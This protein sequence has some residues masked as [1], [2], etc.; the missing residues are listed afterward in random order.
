MMNEIVELKIGRAPYF[1]FGICHAAFVAAAT[2]EWLEGHMANG[3]IDYIKIM[4][5]INFFMILSYLPLAWA[6]V[7]ID[8]RFLTL[9]RFPTY[10]RVPLESI[11]RLKRGVG[12]RGRPFAAMFVMYRKRNGT[13]GELVIPLDSYPRPTVQRFFASLQAARPDLKVPVIGKVETPRSWIL[14]GN[15]TPPE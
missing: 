12:F 4:A 13:E 9:R 1:F 14:P 2:S 10:A 5:V 11:I 3:V 6:L 15:D 7:R 8:Q